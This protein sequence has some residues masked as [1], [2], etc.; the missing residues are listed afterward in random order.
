M[1]TSRHDRAFARTP[2][3]G[4]AG[5]TLAEMLLVVAITA[6]AAGLV[7]GRGLPGQSRIDRAALQSFVRSVRAEAMRTDRRIALAAGRDG[8]SLA[9][10]TKTLALAPDHQVF[11]SASGGGSAIRFDPDGS[12]DGGLVRALGPGGEDRIVIAP[13]TGALQ[14]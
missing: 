1:P 6:L 12:S 10:G 5:V 11:T 7:V 3:N 14:P 2:A 8:H 13:V 4:E 9:A